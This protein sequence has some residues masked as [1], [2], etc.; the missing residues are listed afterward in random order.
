MTTKHERGWLA[1]ALIAGLPLA[2][3]AAAGFGLAARAQDPPA[4]KAPAPA[5]RPA[6]P[7]IWITEV[8]RDADTGHAQLL[9]NVGRDMGLER[10]DVL[11]VEREG[12]IVAHA[13]I[14]ASY[15]DVSVASVDEVLDKG[16]TVSRGDWIR[17]RPG[18]KHARTPA[19][20][21][22]TNQVTEVAD[23]RATVT[24]GRAL[25][26]HTGDEATVIRDGRPVARIK[27]ETV[28]DAASSGPIVEG[29]V[30]KGDRVDFVPAEHAGAGRGRPAGGRDPL[31]PD[32]S[33]DE[34]RR[35]EREAE[36][37]KGIDFVATSFLGVVGEIEHPTP[38]LAPCHY[39]VLVRRVI[40]GS[41]AEKAKIRAGDRVIAIDE[42]VVR[43]P[44]EIYRGV[45]RRSADFVRV[46]IA[47][48]DMI[49][50]VSADFRK[51]Y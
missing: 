10:G 32:L 31:D 6:D 34:L 36:T 5:D 45:Q 39:G 47:R 24:G 38:I 1:A 40:D 49:Q 30:R 44:S 21:P 17:P 20:A 26:I 7:G 43:T 33:R 9:L 37:P 46:M 11:D 29:E 18:A 50:T 2:G 51:R 35:L 13:S 4:P 22:S 8:D 16:V 48:D 25:G 28:D 41:P 3:L 14:V 12:K 19:A 42:R 23:G 27:L 15:V